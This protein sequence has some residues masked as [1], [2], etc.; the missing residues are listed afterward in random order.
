V[1]TPNKTCKKFWTL[2]FGVVVLGG[3]VLGFAAK[4]TMESSTFMVSH[5][6]LAYQVLDHE[7]RLQV[8]E[9][10]Q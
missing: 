10:K 4:S 2:L 5:K 1:N 6:P 9:D 7:K 8:L 3:G